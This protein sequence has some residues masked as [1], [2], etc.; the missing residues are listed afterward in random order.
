[1]RIIS[2]LVGVLF[3]LLA[4]I[5]VATQQE[6]KIVIGAPLQIGMSKDA[7][8]SR[9]AERGLTV[10]ENEAT[11]TWLVT[12]KNDRDEYDLVGTLK[13]TNSRLSWASHRLTS[14][15]RTPERR[16]LSAIFILF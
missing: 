8:I 13:F 6:E 1:M 7:A 10:T 14:S 5:P 3:C 9:I 4:A 15:V 16:N 12:D 2:F 11:G